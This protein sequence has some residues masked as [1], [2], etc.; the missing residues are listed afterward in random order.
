[1]VSGHRLENLHWGVLSIVFVLWCTSLAA[2]SSK[3][4]GSESSLMPELPASLSTAGEPNL[5]GISGHPKLMNVLTQAWKAR[6][7]S[8]TPRTHHLNADGSPTF[9]NRLI[10]ETSPYLLQHA[11]NPVNWRPWGDEAFAQARALK[12]PVL[13]SVGYSTCHW[14]HVMERESFEDLEIA[15][16]INE[17]FV[18]IKVD[19]E[20]RPDVDDIYMG[21]VHLLH[22][23]GGLPGRGH[24]GGPRTFFGGTYFPARDRD[25]VHEKFLSILKELRERHRPRSRGSGEKITQRLRAQ[26]QAQPPGK[27]PDADALERAAG[28]CSAL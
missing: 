7:S 16:Y 6:G 22:G 2:C 25:R 27:V 28:L 10:M 18:A 12:R 19:R 8:Y 5:P 17:H 26:A 23:R 3:P 20:E 9:I 11:H 21:A 1:M 15:R 24:D 4:S 14:C 13:L